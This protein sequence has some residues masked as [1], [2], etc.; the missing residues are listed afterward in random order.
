MVEFAVYGACDLQSI[1]TVLCTPCSSTIKECKWTTRNQ[2]GPRLCG[3]SF[4]YA[5]VAMLSA[6]PDFVSDNESL[7]IKT[8][9]SG[10]KIDILRA[11]RW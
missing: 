11:Q 9:P 2:N 1:E 6:M 7:L 5:A 4:I 3:N 10:Q 8:R